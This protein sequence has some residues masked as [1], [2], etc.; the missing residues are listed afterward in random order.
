ML[1]A[2]TCSGVWCGVI[3]AGDVINPDEKNEDDYGYRFLGFPVGAL[4]ATL[5]HRRLAPNAPMFRKVLSR[6][7]LMP[8]VPLCLTYAQMCHMFWISLGWDIPRQMW[9]VITHDAKM[10]H[11]R[12][13]M[14]VNCNPQKVMQ[15]IREAGLGKGD[16]D[17]FKENMTVLWRVLVAH[18]SGEPLPI[19]N[20]D[21]PNDML[22]NIQQYV[23]YHSPPMSMHEDLINEL[24]LPDSVRL[25]AAVTG[26]TAVRGE[27]TNHEPPSV[28]RD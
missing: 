3:V 8:L 19:A 16:P 15:L 21:E 1:H 6:A 4:T 20:R 24:L 13:T 14:D 23:V 2:F 25:W 18:N 27:L 9:G 7:L 17:M 28:F 12:V 26:K 5:L 22:R 11:D 10:S